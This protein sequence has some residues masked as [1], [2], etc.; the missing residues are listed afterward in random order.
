MQNN[1]I[2]PVD[3]VSVEPTNSVNIQPTNSGD[4]QIV[5]SCDDQPVNESNKRTR[6][7]DATNLKL[8]LHKIGKNVHPDINLSTDVL[9]VINNLLLDM[10]D[11]IVFAADAI[12][13]YAGVHTL[14]VKEIQAA[15]PIVVPPSL[16]VG[17]VQVATD[18][19]NNFKPKLLAPGPKRKSKATQNPDP[20]PEPTS[21]QSI[22]LTSAGRR[23]VVPRSTRAGLTMSVSRVEYLIRAFSRTKRIGDGTPVYLAAVLDY[24]ATEMLSQAGE[25]AK[26]NNI[27]M[28]KLPH[29]VEALQKNE[30][31]KR[32]AA[33]WLLAPDP[34]SADSLS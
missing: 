12:A 1:T 9:L 28:I 7:V 17:A 5:N 2:V 15:T 30:G 14:S 27:N 13:T 32:I 4:V 26:R 20:I 33:M 18:A 23:K 3:Q 25:I 8:Y 34:E 29:L 6:N 16:A 22:D 31:L 11:Q 10:H 21:G 24:L 19:T